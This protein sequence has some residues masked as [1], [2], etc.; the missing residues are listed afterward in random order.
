[1]ISSLLAVLGGLG[2]FLLGMAI[3]TEGLKHL[4]GDALRRALERFTTNPVTGAITGAIGTA[5]LQ[6]SSATTVMAVGFAGADLLTFSQTLGI[7][8]GANLGTTITGWLVA[9]LGFKLSLSQIVMPL[10]FIGAMMRLLGG[11]TARSIGY[12]LA[13]FGLVFVGISVLQTAMQGMGDVLTPDS[14]PP[15]TLVGRFE[16]LLIGIAITLVTQ[17]SSAGVATAITAVHVGAITM[18]QA[19]AMVIGMDVGTTFTAALASVGGGVNARRTGFAHV[20]YNVITGVGAFII[21][22]F[23]VG[24]WEHYA[25]QAVRSD[26]EIALV[27]FHTFFNGLGV[28]LALPLTSQFANLVIKLVPAQES[29]LTR[30]LDRSLLRDSAVAVD[31]VAATLSETAKHVFDLMGRVL[32]SS[33]DEDERTLLLD[34]TEE[35][36][37]ETRVYLAQIPIANESPKVRSRHVACLHILDHLSRMIRRGRMAQRGQ[38]LLDDQSFR[39]LASRVGKML[40]DWSQ[41]EAFPDESEPILRAMWNEIDSSTEPFRKGALAQAAAGERTTDETLQSLDSIRW[42]RRVVYHAWRITHHLSKNHQSAET[43]TADEI[44]PILDQ[45]PQTAIIP[46]SDR[47]DIDRAVDGSSDH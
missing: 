45:P 43:T 3:M 46:S 1:M 7:I 33:I 26:P 4:A 10:V 22:P 5:I 31:A 11:R 41:H 19:A 35:A 27:A 47:A 44:F 42:L 40:C 23:F 32:R 29:S 34:Q 17:S 21:L 37:E 38:Q 15:N 6:S 20:I 25:P 8:F 16:L 36:I 9:F 13:G 28:L 39:S 18:P 2:L 12:T 24:G 14:F 30:Q